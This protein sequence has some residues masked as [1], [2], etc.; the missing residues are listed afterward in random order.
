M[1]FIDIQYTVLFHIELEYDGISSIYSLVTVVL[2]K[3]RW[4][5]KICATH[6]LLYVSLFP[7]CFFPLIIP[8][9]IN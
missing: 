3:F 7:Y 2:L 4:N 6:L 5:K 1:K 9:Y 8:Q